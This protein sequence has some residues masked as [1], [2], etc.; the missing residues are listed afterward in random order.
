[1]LMQYHHLEDY[2]SKWMNGI[3]I[4][5]LLPSQKCLGAPPGIAPIAVGSRGWEFIDRNSFIGHGWYSDLRV[6]R[7]FADDWGDW[8]SFPYNNGH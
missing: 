2:Q 1:M 3:L 5:A 7:K 6:W 8:A 4:Y